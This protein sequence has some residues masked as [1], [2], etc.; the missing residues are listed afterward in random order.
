M[1]Q[2]VCVPVSF[3]ECRAWQQTRSLPGKR[4]GY[5]ATRE[6]FAALEYGPDRDEDAEFAALTFAGVAALAIPGPRLVAVAQADGVGRSAED[7]DFGAV[8][9]TAPAWECV[10]ALFVDEP[11]AAAA[12]HAAR[13]AAAGQP[14]DAAWEEDAVQELVA[15]HDLLWHAPAEL[16]ALINGRE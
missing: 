11:D 2:L 5:A 10:T 6:L 4:R 14:L 1:A 16:S 13:E 7:A 3:E 12:V 9:V 15:R 8:W